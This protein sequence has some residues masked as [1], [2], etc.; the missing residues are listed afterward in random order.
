M[1][2]KPSRQVP[3]TSGNVKEE[4]TGD[5]KNPE[6]VRP[7][8]TI[9][10]DILD[11]AKYMLFNP[12]ANLIIMPLLLLME[13]MAVKII[14]KNVAYTE[15]DYKAYME[16][17]EMIKDG[18]LNYSE[19]EGG[20]GPLVYPA[21]HVM[22]YKFM[23]WLTD[24]MGSLETGQIMFR[25][26][27]VL[28]VFYQFMIYYKLR[29]PPWCTVLACL[30][31]RIHSIYVLRMFNDC[32]TTFFIICTY[33]GYHRA[34]TLKSSKIKFIVSTLTSL[35]Y[36]VAVSIKMNALLY[37][38]G[39]AISL[40]LINDGCIMACIPSLIVMIAWQIGVA[41]PFLKAAPWEYLNGAFNFQRQFLFKWSVN[42]QFIGEDG[43]LST[44]FQKSLL[45][46][47]CIMLLSML[48]IKYPTF[49]R[50]AY[51]SI[52][53]PFSRVLPSG[54]NRLELFSFFF[55][56]SNFIGVIFSRSL[57]YQFLAWYHWTIP[58]LIAWS[59]LPIYLGPVWYVL[60]EYCWN[61][62]PPN[63]QASTLLITLNCLLLILILTRT[64]NP[65]TTTE[66]PALQEKKTK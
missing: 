57:H 11:A 20:T 63:P 52:M 1:S 12:E 44:A 56:I 15:I 41:L 45:A 4:S 8:V 25:Y 42:W 43:F 62:Y 32:F 26:F 53:H 61:S 28:T 38:P 33:L 64:N 24:G 51:K 6:F 3:K 29:I 59:G 17:I 36:S 65:Q 46:S 47:Q 58:I 55:V 9:G 18:S 31:K 60:H 35:I 48:L 30:S 40:Y 10:R 49:I 2:E 66:D 13:S 14:I 7:P 22:M 21:G 37:F 39:V 27:Y 54:E 16:Q 50:D 5:V 34:A 19:I 23:H